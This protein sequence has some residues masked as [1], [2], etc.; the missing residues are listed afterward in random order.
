MSF[1]LIATGL[2]KLE[3]TENKYNLPYLKCEKCQKCKQ[4]DSFG[5]KFYLFDMSVH[6][7]EA[8]RDI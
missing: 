2:D 5:A 3:M 1:W 7:R 4:R 8:I 6:D